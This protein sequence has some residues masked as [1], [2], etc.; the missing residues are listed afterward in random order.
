MWLI[1]TKARAIPDHSHKSSVQIRGWRFSPV[2]VRSHWSCILTS[3]HSFHC[4]NMAPL[5]HFCE[6]IFS[7]TPAPSCVLTYS[8]STVP[9]WDNEVYSSCV[10]R[11]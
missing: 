9:Q 11:L 8:K 2:L 1:K 5:T 6:E 10:A 4:W 7:Y 3:R